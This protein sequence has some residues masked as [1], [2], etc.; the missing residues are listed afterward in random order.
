MGFGSWLYEAASSTVSGIGSG[1]SYVASGVVE[2]A[3]QVT[4]P[5]IGGAVNSLQM[6]GADVKVEWAE[7]RLDD[8]I[9]VVAHIAAPV[10][11]GVTN[12]LQMMGA[13]VKVDW[14]ESRLDQQLKVIEPATTWIAETGAPAVWN[15]GAYVMAVS[16]VGLV[17]RGV[18]ELTGTDLPDWAGGG[19]ADRNRKAE[20]W[21]R[22][23][24]TYIYEN[25]GRASALATQ[26]IT[27]G[28]SS[29][30]GFVG[31]IVR[32]VGYEYTLR[33]LA[34]GVY[35][36]GMADDEK[37][38]LISD[39]TL[40][41]WTTGLNDTL[42]IKKL[43]DEDSW[44]E[45]KSVET[46]FGRIQPVI[47]NEA[48]EEVPNP[49]MSQEMTL[50]YGPQAVAEALAFWAVGA[51]TAGVGGAAL[52]ALRVSSIGTKVI[53]VMKSIDMLADA[54][55]LIDK[56][57]KAATKVAI[58]EERLLQLERAGASASKILKAEKAIKK[59]QT[60]LTKAEGIAQKAATSHAA[61]AGKVLTTAEEKLA[62]LKTAGASAED[63]AKAELVV[64]Q[65]QAADLAAQELLKHTADLSSKASIAQAEEAI[66]QTAQLQATETSKTLSAA[67]K[68]LTSLEKS[69]ASADDIVNAK[70]AVEHAQRAADTS[71][72]LL[73]ISTTRAAQATEQAS[74]SSVTIV[75][76]EESF[77]YMQRINNGWDAG[78]YKAGGR[79][80]NP[81]FDTTAK[82]TEL[83]GAGL[84]FGMGVHADKANTEAE[85]KNNTGMRDANTTI[86]TG[87]Q[88]ERN[89]T[90]GLSLEDLNKLNNGGSTLLP[91]T[92]KFN[93][94]RFD[95]SSNAI[96]PYSSD[97]NGGATSTTFNNRVDGT[98]TTL[99]PEK[100]S[101]ITLTFDTP[102]EAQA[103]KESLGNNK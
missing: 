65:A 96:T 25:P 37:A 12:G 3:A 74:A 62:A 41:H 103:V 53:Q 90:I 89:K 15:G 102:E 47:I 14:A 27:N 38:N 94:L 46:A 44:M 82:V 11:G 10:V 67:Q 35:N 43:F 58:A 76:V 26:G 69:G 52:A 87:E 4:A 70:T 72:D 75:Q 29:T 92:D 2:V 19:L 39:R 18:E 16:P 31:D 57:A 51:V 85:M 17:A 13:D 49:Y 5:I 54:A 68:N 99:D 64:Q 78:L 63:V 9:N 86:L 83:G 33:P 7:S 21:T 61:D 8:Q 73:H 55:K 45:N 59:A 84:A 40:F 71:Q 98:T 56:V 100:P 42:Q 101:I 24:G 32:N 6:L 66:R 97:G 81:F 95:G 80:L 93:P 34:V 36:L 28:V 48:G 77:S 50:L 88:A 20:E 91:L 79:W 60:V 23:M 30:V 1:I 22:D